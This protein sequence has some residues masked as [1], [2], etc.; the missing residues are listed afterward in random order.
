MLRVHLGNP[1][2]NAFGGLLYEV[3]RKTEGF[4]MEQIKIS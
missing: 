4:Q 2:L 1:I 3:K